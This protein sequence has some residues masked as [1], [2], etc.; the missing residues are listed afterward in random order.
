[1]NLDRLP[2]PSPPAETATRAAGL[3][4]AQVR[5]AYDRQEVLK[6]IDLEIAAGE[7]VCLLGPSGCGKTT[8]LRLAAGLEV[9]QHGTISVAGEAYS[10]PAETRPPESRRVGLMFQDFALFPHLSV[11]DNVAFGLRG[12]PAATRRRIALGLLERVGLGRTASAYPHVL[13]GGEQQRVALARALAPNPVIMLLDE[14][15]SGLDARLRDQVRDDTLTLLKEQGVATLLVT[16]D[17]EEA[18][19]MADRIAL[20]ADGRLIQVGSAEALYFRPINGFAAG[21]FGELNRLQGVVSNGA[22]QTPVGHIP[23]AGLP[24]GRTVDVLIRLEA[25]SPAG[26]GDRAAIEGRVAAVRFLGAITQL[27]VRLGGQASIRARLRAVHAPSVGQSVRLALD[28]RYA[29]VFPS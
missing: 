18:L 12:V 5:H 14:P 6:G 9:L 28:P 4:F 7:I 11:L 16:H 27:D 22:V 2:A 8:M 25:F 23:C 1:M 17:A 3:A 13:S 19:F 29:F 15:F 21:F 24:D 20:M 10:T 26:S